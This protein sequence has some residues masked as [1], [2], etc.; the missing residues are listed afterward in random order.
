MI[1]ILLLAAICSLGA[2]ATKP[3]AEEIC[4]AQW[5]KP[6]TDAAFERFRAATEDN[7]KDLNLDNANG[8]GGDGLLQRARMLLTLTQLLGEFKESQSLR[9]LRT[10]SETCDDPDLIQTALRGTLQEYQVPQRYI[11][12]LESLEAFMELTGATNKPFES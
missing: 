7:W 1:R 11:D 5:I 12:M 9:D 6:R 8:S 10:L 4:S 2:C 3:P